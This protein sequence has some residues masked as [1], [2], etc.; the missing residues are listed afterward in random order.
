M[1]FLKHSTVKIYG[2]QNQ[3]TDQVKLERL[4]PLQA[5]ATTIFCIEREPLIYIHYPELTNSYL[6]KFSSLHPLTLS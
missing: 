1:A 3:I 6:W 4:H 5:E 2:N